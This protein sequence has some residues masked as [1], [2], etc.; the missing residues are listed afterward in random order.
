[1]TRKRITNHIVSL[2]GALAIA[3]G[4][5]ATSTIA[6]GPGNVTITV[7]AVGKK[8]TVPPAVKTDDV[9]LYLNKERTQLAGWTKAEKL[10]LAVLI[11]DSL[12]SSVANQWSDLRAFFD[13]QPA[14]TYISVAYVRNGSAM[15]AQD[16][17][18]NHE[19]AGK[20]LRIPIGSGGAFS[21]PYL[22]LLDLMK[23]W[24]ASGDR[25]SILLISSGIDYFR[26]GGFGP[27][28]PDL[29]PAI[30][31]AQKQ[32][33]NIWSIYAPDAGHRS[34]GFFRATNAQNNL[35]QLSDETG[36]ES[37]SLGLGEP[38]TF[39]YYLDEIGMH[40]SNQYLL[41]F[42]GSAGK[43][44]RFERVHAVTEIPKVEFMAPAQAFLPP[45][46]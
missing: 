2:L 19:L 32:N 4:F 22:S 29:D 34:R 21:S 8:D 24:P 20:A 45:A 6:A 27:R 3:L 30:E 10:Y 11:D 41:T 15:L 18:N 39:K 37:Y 9:Q 44:G 42:N 5:F 14:T 26:G 16:F 35:S 17:T 33:I 46:Q 23:R 38:V 40:L 12:D 43:K 31:R 1:M 7:T 36:A 28:S 13:A 25:R